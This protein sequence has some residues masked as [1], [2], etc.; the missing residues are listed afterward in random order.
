MASYVG[1]D[2]QHFVDSLRGDPNATTT[3]TAALTTDWSLRGILVFRLW[4]LCG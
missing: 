1:V 4:G 3:V 2:H